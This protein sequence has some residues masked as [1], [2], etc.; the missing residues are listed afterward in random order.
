MGHGASV[1]GFKSTYQQAHLQGRLIFFQ[2]LSTFASRVC[3]VNF[4]EK[5]NSDEAVSN[6]STLH[7][8]TTQIIYYAH[9]Y[10]LFRLLQF[11]PVASSATC[12]IEEMLV[13]TRE[14]VIAKSAPKPWCCIPPVAQCVTNVHAHAHDTVRPHS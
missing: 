8:S 12:I 5:I 9:N 4:S 14:H 3:C 10:M 2:E 6:S 11:L 1:E 13:Y 7:Y